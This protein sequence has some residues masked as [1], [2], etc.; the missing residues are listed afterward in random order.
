MIREHAGRYRPFCDLCGASPNNID[1]FATR[2]DAQEWMAKQGWHIHSGGRQH[3]CHDCAARIKADW[4]KELAQPP[5]G[6]TDAWRRVIHVNA[7]PSAGV[8]HETR[9]H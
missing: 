5:S 9:T 7:N 3:I 8:R 1:V 2:E 4:E 6:T